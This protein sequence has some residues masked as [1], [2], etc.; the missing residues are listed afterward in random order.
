M[1]VIQV[2]KDQCTRCNACAESCPVSLFNSLGDSDYPSIPEI[3]E[4]RCIHCGHCSAVCPTGALTHFYLTDSEEEPLDK[5]FLINPDD[6]A[7]YFKSRR[8]IRKFRNKAV[9]CSKIERLMEIVRYAPTGTNSQR[10]HWTVV[11]DAELIRKMA[12][13]TIEWMKKVAEVDPAMA[14][15]LGMRTLI[16]AFGNGNDVICRDAPQVII[17]HTPTIYTIG[18]KDAVIAASHLELLLP[19][20]GLGGCWGGY[21]MVAL[22]QYPEL[23]KTIGLDENSTV[24]AALLVG[25][26]KYKY[27]KIPGRKDAVI[28]WL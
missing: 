4:K 22:Q 10:T 14:D 19:S 18:A 24:H 15:R 25:Y 1:A 8:S 21:L 28:N 6:L 17:T 11:S 27:A 5:S 26:P 20:V 12:S 7:T 2:N 23:K 13:L 3:N 16:A 9:E